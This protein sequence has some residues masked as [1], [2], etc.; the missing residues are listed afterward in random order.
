VTDRSVTHGTFALEHFYPAPPVRVFDAWA[1]PTVKARWF[2]GAL[3][4]AAAPMRMDFR[5][6]GTEQTVSRTDDG[7]VIV[8]E[9]L[10]RDIVPAERIVVA[11]WID[12]DGQ[13]ISVS[14]F[15]AEFRSDGS[16]T[17]LVVTEQGAYLDGRDSPD[18]RA[19]GIRS[20]LDALALELESSTADTLGTA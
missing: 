5:I 6:G 1:D 7:A 20:Q 9:G 18:S 2:A 8:Y 16:G 14:Q 15:T 17:R 19:I 13:R 4:P 10:F 3:D 11:N 12:V